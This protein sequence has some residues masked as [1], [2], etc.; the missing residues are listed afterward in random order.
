MSDGQKHRLRNTP[1]EI[2]A[3]SDLGRE[4][5]AVQKH[6]HDSGSRTNLKVIPIPEPL[7]RVRASAALHNYRDYH[8]ERVHRTT[9]L[10]AI[11][12]VNQ[13]NTP[14]SLWSQKG[15]PDP[16]GDTYNC[17]RSDLPLGHLTDDQLANAVFLHNHREL[18]LNAILAGEPS[19]IALLTAA[20][21]R[22]RW[23][24]REVE[25]MRIPY[26]ELL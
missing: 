15:E 12:Q 19:S 16:H 18:D 2:I 24:S 9:V 1:S 20:K 4:N 11:T 3:G 17:K 10:F 21:E 25:R 7:A 22:I 13:M 26:S 23:L 6:K 8:T 5:T 14:S